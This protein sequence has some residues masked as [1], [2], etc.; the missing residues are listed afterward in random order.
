MQQQ[1]AAV[2]LLL[3][4]GVALLLSACGG[5]ELEALTSDPM[6]TGSIAG[7]ELVEESEAEAS[8]GGVLGKP[9]PA[10]VRRV[11]SLESE[12]DVPRVFDDAMAR[13]EEAGWEVQSVS[14]REQGFVALRD[15][16]GTPA[17]LTVAVNLN[18]EIPPAPGLFVSLEATGS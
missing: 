6:A 13:A 7:A 4:A 10:E 2:R 14:P 12:G 18:P 11:Y 8:D 1:P 16:D 3:A 15:I 5:G 17:R 9:S